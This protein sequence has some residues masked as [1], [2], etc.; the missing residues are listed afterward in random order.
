MA[1]PRLLQCGR[2][3]GA[4]GRG[5]HRNAACPHIC[6]RGRGAVSVRRYDAQHRFCAAARWVHPLSAIRPVDRGEP[7]RRNDL[8][9]WCLEFCRSRSRYPDGTDRSGHGQYRVDRAC[10]LRPLPARVRRRRH[11]TARGDGRS[12]RADA[13]RTR[14]SA[15]AKC[16]QTGQA[17]SQRGNAQHAARSGQGV[18]L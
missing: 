11:L 13:A 1:D 6:R 18:E 3:D 2:P 5:V 7:A 12:H 14:R 17:G 16:R 15:A 10:T 8:R 4:G 9:H